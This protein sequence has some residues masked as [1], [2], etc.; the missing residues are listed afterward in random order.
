MG[1]LL[2]SLCIATA[3]LALGACTSKPLLTPNEQLHL[4]Q[5]VG[6][7]QVKKAVLVTLKKRGWSV[8]RNAPGLVQAEI[9]VRNKFFAAVDIPYSASGY[10]IRYRDS[11]EMGYHDGKIHRNYNRW[12]YALDRNILRE[13]K[14]QQAL[15]DDSD[16]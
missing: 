8:T 14:G 2:R 5:P 4:A 6:D 3:L 13:L 7:V 12:V 16:E 1:P 11:R 15:N 10:Q 9:E